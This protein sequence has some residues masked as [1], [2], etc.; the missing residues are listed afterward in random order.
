VEVLATTEQSPVAVLILELAKEIY[1]KE[2][3]DAVQNGRKCDDDFKKDFRYKL[4]MAA[5]AERLLKRVN[6][7]RK[8]INGQ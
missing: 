3:K 2:T 7:A 5:G 1:D 6:D 8:S 4:G